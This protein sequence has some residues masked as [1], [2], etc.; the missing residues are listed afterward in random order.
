[1]G[2]KRGL[3]MNRISVWAAGVCTAACG[4]IAVAAAPAKDPPPIASYWMDVSTQSGLGAGMT[5]G[6]RPSM[7]DVM[8]MM[9]GGGSSVGHTINLRL[10]SKT[11]PSGAAQADHWIPAG[12][13]MGPSLPL[14]TPVNE[15]ARETPS[16]PMQYQQP[17]GRM[18]IYWGC[19]E[20]V[21]AGQ[22]TAI[23]FSQMVPGKVPP[24]MAAMASMAHV[25]SGPNGAPGFGRWPND[26]DSRAVPAAG[27]LVGAHKV[28]ANY[29]PPIAF[30]LGQD[31]MPG[32]GLREAGALPSG[33]ARL[34]WQP[35]ATATGYALAM[36]GSNQNGDV[37]MWSSSRS[38]SMVTL[39]YLS[40]SEVKRL[41]AAG[42]VL[43]PSTS[44]CLL[45]AEVAAA[46]P[47]GMVTMIGYGPE[48]NFAEAPKAPKWVTKVRYKTTASL[49]RGMAGMMGASDGGA[50]PEQAQQ[51]QQQPRKKKR[52]GLGD[53][54]Q[55]AT[56]APIPQ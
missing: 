33:A 4:A 45:P 16:M 48:A 10:A 34:M 50:A 3:S 37:V 31:F 15:P 46:S 40:P 55:G 22:P 54:I 24:Q 41:I 35:A 49:M 29:A 13:Q 20:H 56:G 6:G 42:A 9:S 21:S 11:K 25:V 32:L 30:N 12:L 17:K 23:D 27:S 43:P 14:L 28:Q 5:P 7:S 26:K 39:D 52:F 36:F 53:L 47:A 38:A 2:L 19:G 1:M 18:L 8:S 44:E 51:P